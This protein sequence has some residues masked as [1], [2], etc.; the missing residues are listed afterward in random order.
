MVVS[1]TDVAELDDSES[2]ANKPD[3]EGLGDVEDDSRAAD[4]EGV[5][6]GDGVVIPQK[7][8]LII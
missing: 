4:L 7:V 1:L 5:D 8:E 3:A 6:E 2:E